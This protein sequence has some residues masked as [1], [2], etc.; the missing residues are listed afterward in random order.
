VIFFITAYLIDPL[1]L[2]FTTCY[3]LPAETQSICYIMF[4]EEEV[5]SK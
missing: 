4:K 5:S 2:V 1:T 3:T